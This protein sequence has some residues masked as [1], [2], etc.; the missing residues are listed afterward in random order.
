MDYESTQGNLGFTPGSKDV[1]VQG[2]TNMLG[3]LPNQQEV[4]CQFKQSGPLVF[5]NLEFAPNA[6]V[7]EPNRRTSIVFTLPVTPESDESQFYGGGARVLWELG[8]GK[9]RFALG[10]IL[11]NSPSDRNAA[12]VFEADTTELIS[13][14]L[15]TGWYFAAT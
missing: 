14:I 6:R 4:T 15:I 12:L 11:A 5:F 3:N 9:D 2:G 7:I 13:K 10:V 8:E 1:T